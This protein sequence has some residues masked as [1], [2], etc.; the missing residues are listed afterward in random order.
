M[1]DIYGGLELNML[2]SFLEGALGFLPNDHRFESSQGHWRFIW[3]LTSSLC[4]ISRD[5]CNLAWTP[6]FIKNE[7]KIFLH[8]LKKEKYLTYWSVI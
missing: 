5:A 1:V 7:R 4:V 3:S 8:T 6:T 2:R